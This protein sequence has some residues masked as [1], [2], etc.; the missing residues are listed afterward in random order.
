MSTSNRVRAAFFNPG[1]Q[2]KIE[3]IWVSTFR[4]NASEWAFL[5]IFTV[6]FERLF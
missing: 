6:A 2:G 5:R 4:G 3:I 1:L